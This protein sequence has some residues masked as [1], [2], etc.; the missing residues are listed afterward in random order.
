MSTGRAIRWVSSGRALAA[1]TVSACAVMASPSSALAIVLAPT[2][3][4][5]VATSPSG[6][7]L[8]ADKVTPSDTIS[9][10]GTSNG[11][12]GAKI[13]LRCYTGTSHTTLKAELA[14]S[15]EG[16]FSYTGALDAISGPPCVLRAVPSATTE[17]EEQTTHPEYFR[18]GG[19]SPFAGPTLAVGERKNSPVSGT[20]PNKA[21]L[22]RYYLFAPQ[23]EGGFDYDSLGG[24]LISDSYLYD[25]VTF[26]SVTLDY[27][28]AWFWN[29]NGP[30]E[31]GG[32]A[33]TRSELEVDGAS[34]Y[35]AGNIA[36]L[37][38]I[39]GTE[40]PGFPSLSYN[41]SVDPVTG[42][43]I[44]EETDG[45]VKCAPGATVYPPTSTSCT[46]WAS[47]GVEA[48]MRVT[49]GEA[50]RVAKATLWFSSLDGQAHRL[51]LL[52]DEEFYHPERDGELDFP[53][54]GEGLKKYT[55]VGQQLPAAPAAP[56]SFFVKG[57][58]AAADGSHKSG[59]GAVTFSSAPEGETIV[60]PT[61]SKSQY[62]WVELHYVRTV[63]AGGSVALGFTYSDAFLMSEVE[64]LAAT[65]QAAYT[66]SVAIAS[67]ASGSTTA[68]AT[69]TVTGTASDV[70]GIS[71]VVVDGQAVT[72]AANGG[73]SASVPLTAGANTITATA[74]NI[75]GDTASAHTTVT[76]APPS[77]PPTLTMRGTP[78]ATARGV[79]LT[80]VCT[81]P[82]GQTCDGTAVLT[83]RERRKGT[84]VLG[85]S[86]RRQHRA[87][88]R[89]RHVTITVG[90]TQLK[91]AAGQTE[92]VLVR[93]NPTGRRLLARFHRLPV[94]LVVTLSNGAAGRPTVVVKRKLAIRAP[95]HKHRRRGH[96]GSHRRK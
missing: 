32:P 86:A 66:P 85:V 10:T 41:Y 13:D 54:A 4:H 44:L 34:A 33:A 77:S 69:A 62:S 19:V 61:T 48:H 28:N 83:T 22:E 43:L 3:S 75:F 96:R 12:E 51:D 73:W 21:L 56:A 14:L 36:Y 42:N 80:L 58:A 74:T 45:I 84:R 55:I 31:E 46:S 87:R 53:W 38:G 30:G 8:M 11:T 47:T 59:E 81:A 52:E 5:V 50:G 88:K 40:L 92:T 15:A 89:T 7:Y 1:M 94:A 18:P 76:Y 9:V 65:A 93:L 17:E 35:V 95:K 90:R 25:P 26:A 37:N 6:T 60:A 23:L 67:P 16:K 27:C 20:G 63:P 49:Q 79:Q 78:R 71:S 64:G 29:G 57:S 39:K 72:V 91:L 68:A 82:T 24:C 2:E 70:S